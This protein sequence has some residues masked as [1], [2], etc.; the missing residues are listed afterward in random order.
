[1]SYFISNLKSIH[2]Q[3][4]AQICII[5]H[6]QDSQI[7]IYLV[8]SSVNFFPLAVLSRS[9]FSSCYYLMFS[10]CSL[11]CGENL[12]HDFYFISGKHEVK[13][14]VIYYMIVYMITKKG[15]TE[16][17]TEPVRPSAQHCVTCRSLVAYLAISSSP[18]FPVFPATRRNM[19]PWVTLF[20]ASLTDSLCLQPWNK[21]KKR[22]REKENKGLKMC[23]KRESLGSLMW[24]QLS[25]LK[26]NKAVV[27]IKNTWASLSEFSEKLHLKIHINVR[28]LI[29]HK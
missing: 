26:C 18:V 11:N 1:M 25:G 12:Y 8:Y 3:I 19:L 20:P 5:L 14:K 24:M 22:E 28:I 23:E 6:G 15:K 21:E 4:H 16:R 2:I 29:F 27:F 13:T 7:N 17:L 9:A 10:F